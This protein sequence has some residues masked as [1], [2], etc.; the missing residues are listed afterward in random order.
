MRHN[1]NY[2]Q[3][4]Q[5]LSQKKWL[6]NVGVYK[7]KIS[8]ESNLERRTSY[9]TIAELEPSIMKSK[10]VCVKLEVSLEDKVYP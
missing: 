4:A 5:L 9:Q 6:F 3:F 2:F 7:I 10:D 8:R 1:H